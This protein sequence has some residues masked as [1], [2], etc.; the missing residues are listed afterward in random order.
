MAET[1]NVSGRTQHATDSPATNQQA[2]GKRSFHCRLTAQNDR[3]ACALPNTTT[4]S[5][6]VYR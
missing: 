1:A 2:L 6:D 5:H 3:A 4:L